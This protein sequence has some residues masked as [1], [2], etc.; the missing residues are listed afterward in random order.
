[1]IKK[2]DLS[3]GSEV[4]DGFWGLGKKISIGFLDLLLPVSCLFCEKT[5]DRHKLTPVPICQH[6]EQELPVLRPPFCRLCGFPLG[7]SKIVSLNQFEQITESVLSFDTP[8]CGDCRL[9][10]VDFEFVLAGFSFTGP[11]RTIVHDWKFNRFQPW[12]E[13][14]AVKLGRLLMDR[15]ASDGWDCLLPIPLYYKKYEER[16]FNQ[17]NQLASKLGEIFDLPVSRLLYKEFATPAQSA[18]KREE[19]LTNLKNCFKIKDSYRDFFPGKRIIFVDDI[20]TTG[21]TL[22]TA[23]RAALTAGAEKLAAIVLARSL[24]KQAIKSFL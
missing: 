11:I 15:F 8:V 1:M 17:S 7:S 20:Y 16:G 13:W 2:P 18:L 14:L 22:K 12:G 5:V 23:A 21:A 4:K 3:G 6:D 24:P 9:T 10:P 19:R